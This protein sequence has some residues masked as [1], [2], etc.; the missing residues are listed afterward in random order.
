MITLNEDHKKK[1]GFRAMFCHKEQ[2][3][4]IP[5]VNAGTIWVLSKST[6]NNAPLVTGKSKRYQ[7][8][9]RPLHPAAKG[10]WG[11]LQEENS[12]RTRDEPSL[13]LQISHFRSGGTWIPP[14]EH[15][16]KR[17]DG[18]CGTWLGHH[19]AALAEGDTAGFL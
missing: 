10:V 1:N 4:I 7:K 16:E 3:G 18:E 9:K 12:L 13:L 15:R 17:N 8:S 14:I 2:K 19:Q 5:L 6:M 11:I